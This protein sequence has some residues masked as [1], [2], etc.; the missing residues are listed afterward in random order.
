MIATTGTT[1]STELKR[2]PLLEVSRQTATI[3]TELD[4]A[5]ARV[6]ELG[7]FIPGPEVRAS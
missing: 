4:A 5:I 7:Q 3:R 6:P 1:H 2:V